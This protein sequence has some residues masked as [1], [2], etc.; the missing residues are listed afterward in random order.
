MCIC[1]KT[2]TRN[3]LEYCT[4]MLHKHF[5]LILEAIIT[6][7]LLGTVHKFWQQIA[8]RTILC[9]NLHIRFGPK[10]LDKTSIEKNN[11]I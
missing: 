2:T 6:K 4:T 8:Q 1:V 10:F 7:S 9:S 3:T 5:P 11:T